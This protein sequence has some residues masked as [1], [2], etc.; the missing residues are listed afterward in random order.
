M[1][2]QYRFNSQNGPQFSPTNMQALETSSRVCAALLPF[3]HPQTYNRGRSSGYRGNRGYR[4]GG[5]RYSSRGRGERS[6]NDTYETALQKS[7][8]NP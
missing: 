2:D 5:D 7:A 3:S 4:G 1:I 6:S 8:G